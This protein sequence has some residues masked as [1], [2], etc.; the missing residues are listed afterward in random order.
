MTDFEQIARVSHQQTRIVNIKK[1]STQ[2]QNLVGNYRIGKKIGS[3]AYGTVH[4]A[5]QIETG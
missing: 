2:K 4:E 3:G 5:F 1:R